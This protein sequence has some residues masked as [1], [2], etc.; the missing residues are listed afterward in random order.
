MLAKYFNENDQF[1]SNIFFFCSFLFIFRISLENFY[2]IHFIIYFY[3]L[4]ILYFL[5]ESNKPRVII[6]LNSY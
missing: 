2:A 3:L 1:V 4:I 6:R 5:K